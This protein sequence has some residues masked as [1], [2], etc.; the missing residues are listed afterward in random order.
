MICHDWF[1]VHIKMGYY[2]LNKNKLLK[3]A[4]DRYHNDGGKLEWEN[5]KNKYRSLSEKEKEVKRAY[6]RDS[7]RN[8]IED[9]K[10]R[11]KKYQRNYQ[12]AKN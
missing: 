10:N 2:Q 1:F 11:L 5:A 7:Y 9:E 3:K 8:M 12:S 4:K 6:G